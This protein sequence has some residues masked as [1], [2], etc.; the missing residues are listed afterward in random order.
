MAAEP[1]LG[2]SETPTSSPLVP[3]LNE[4]RHLLAPGT[5]GVSGQQLTVNGRRVCLYEYG[6][7]GVRYFSP[8][9]SGASI[10]VGS[11]TDTWTELV[12]ADDRG[13]LLDLHRRSVADGLGYEA[14]FRFAKPGSPGLWVVDRQERIDTRAH[15]AWRGISLDVTDLVAPSRSGAGRPGAALTSA[16]PLGIYFVSRGDAVGRV[17][18]GT[19]GVSGAD[20]VGLPLAM[21]ETDALL[22]ALDERQTG[23]ISVEQTTPAGRKHTT[24]LSWAPLG[25][26]P[27]TP[28]ISLA[29]ADITEHVAATE[30]RRRRL[31]T[32]A[33]ARRGASFRL[34]PGGR[35]RVRRDWLREVAPQLTSYSD[36]LDRAGGAQ[37]RHLRTARRTALECLE[38][39]CVTL[40]LALGDGAQQFVEA[41]LPDASGAAWDCVLL[42]LSADGADEAL[43]ELSRLARTVRLDPAAQLLRSLGNESTVPRLLALLAR[44]GAHEAHVRRRLSMAWGAGDPGLLAQ[45]YSHPLAGPAVP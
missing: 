8:S 3:A 44:V 18:A 21:R 42:P 14:L 43:D 40:T 35:A 12:H 1:R 2:E 25:D 26:D 22:A 17:Q 37:A 10:P 45:R 41:G 9:L 15:L 7:D 13:W 30:A 6:D 33:H 38:G 24:G 29:V 39:Y 27:S 31:H 19:G 5:L 28:L 34:V 32:L 16:V 23:A 20:L 4:P 36:L 11:G